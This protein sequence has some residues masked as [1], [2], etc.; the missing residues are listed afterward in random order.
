[1]SKDTILT[2]IMILL[3][4]LGMMVVML[5]TAYFDAKHRI[6]REREHTAQMQILQQAAKSRIILV[7]PEDK[8]N[9]PEQA[10]GA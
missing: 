4:P 7:F 9:K 2:M 5:A 10:D 8:Q 6:E 1:M 3:P